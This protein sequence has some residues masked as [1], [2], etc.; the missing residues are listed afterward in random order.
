MGQRRRRRH[1]LGAGD[2]N[3]G[4]GVFLDGDVDVFHLIGGLGA[5][6]R[7][8]DD[9]VVHEQHVL[10][11]AFVPSLG[12]AGE[13]A[14]K[15]EI[16]AER[17]H[18]RRLVVRRAPHPAVGHARPLRDGVALRNQ[19]LARARGAEEFVGIAAGAGIGRRGQDALG[20]LGVQRVVEPGDRA[21]GVAERRV[22][23]DVLDPLAI[24]IDF[25]AIAQTF[26]V[27]R[28]GERPPLG[29]DGVL[30]FD[31]VHGGSPCSCCRWRS[32]RRRGRQ[33]GG[34]S[35]A[36]RSEEPGIHNHRRFGC[37]PSVRLLHVW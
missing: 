2:I 33:A 23:G 21:R 29:A 25:A 5:I 24:D 11:G 20:L 8:I 28:A 4:I 17:V 35:G 22:R 15:I 9:G 13:L 1:H 3:P 26:E 6:H 27:F 7:R 36:E 37:G 30:G 31:P 14:V 34:H 19:I 32:P 12:V 16:G 18:Q 10:L